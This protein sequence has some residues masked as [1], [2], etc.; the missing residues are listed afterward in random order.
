VNDNGGV[1]RRLGGVL[2]MLLAAAMPAAGAQLL[3]PIGPQAECGD[4]PRQWA[5]RLTDVQI[6]MRDGV[7]LSANLWLPDEPGRYPVVFA[8]TP[9]RKDDPR[10]QEPALVDTGYVYAQVDVRGTG[11]SGGR[12]ENVFSPAEQADGAEL[13]RWFAA[14][15]RMW[16]QGTHQKVGM[17]GQSYLGITQLFTA[18]QPGV[19]A[20]LGAIFPCKAYSDIYRD[21][22]YHGGILAS[23]FAMEW[24]FG[25][26]LWWTLP[27]APW[28]AKGTTHETFQAWL[29][30]LGNEPV[31]AKA[32]ERPYDDSLFQERSVYPRA[33]EIDV[34][35]YHCGGWYDGF[36]RGTLDVWRVTGEAPDRMVIGPWPHRGYEGFDLDAARQAWFDRWLRGVQNGVDADRSRIRLF[37]MRGADRTKGEWRDETAWPLPSTAF[38]DWHLR[39]GGRLAPEPPGTSE[40]GDVHPASSPTGATLTSG[41]WSNVSGITDF[42]NPDQGPDEATSRTYTTDPFP[43]DVE[44]T[45]PFVLHLWAATTA[46]DVDLFAK[47]S[48]VAPDGA[49]T[50]LTEGFLRASHRALAPPCATPTSTRCSLP[51][52]PFHPHDRDSVQPVPLGEP[53]LYELEI[54]PTANVF[55][56]GHRLRLS[57]STGDHPNHFS[58]PMPGAVTFL[59]DA[60]HPSRLTVPLV[61]RVAA[62]SAP[63]P[64]VQPSVDDRRTPLPATG[65]SVAPVAAA[66]AAL[67]AGLALRRASRPARAAPRR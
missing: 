13:A 6:R 3:P 51:W 37:V 46:P 26:G 60:A 21:I 4:E 30:H 1:I 62:A 43:T 65:P 9:Y 20:D 34:P 35:T 59:H 53:V 24:G 54:W 38:T 55:P 27:P 16:N 40:G 8:M 56:A 67:A 33:H 41:R 48:D 19:E 5:S 2:C 36:L 17:M 18:L 15:P 50:Y 22:V 28:T 42:Q 23:L 10:I 7:C 66:L 12:Y 49:S 14:A 32:L 25:T 44:L 29:A 57:L 64:T 45:G 11:H 52:Q 31:I 39:A 58:P 47:V 63:S 61:Q